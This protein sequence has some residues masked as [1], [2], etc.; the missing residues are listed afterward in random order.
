MHTDFY[1][2]SYGKGM[3]HGYRWE[4]EGKPRAVLQIVHGIAEHAARYD[5]FASFMAK[6]GFLVVAEDHMGHGLSIGDHDAPGYFEGGW[7]KAVADCHRLLSYTRM[8]QPDIPYILLGHSMGSF[9]VRTMLAKYPQADISAA[10]LSGTAWMHRGIINTGH[11]T[12]SLICKTEGPDSHNKMLSNLMFGGNNRR[13][14]RKRTEFDWLTRDAACV[15]AYLADPL[16]GFTVTAALVRDMM[17]GLRFIQEP[18]NLEK[19]RK[20][21]PVLFISGGDDPVGGY[22]EG[23]TKAWKAFLKAGMERCDLR[24]YPMCRHEVLN[25]INKSEVYEFILHWL[26]EQQMIT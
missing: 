2:P 16:C 21:L 10:I 24:L 18:E 1:F 4:P 11:A 3:I 6:Q 17:I 20:D 25:E 14:E 15:D 5:E 23:V 13:V 26:Q 9:M 8:E 19:M 12:A 22:G 7:F